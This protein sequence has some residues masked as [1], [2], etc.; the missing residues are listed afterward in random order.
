MRRRVFITLLCGALM[1]SLAA[2]Q[3]WAY[4]SKDEMIDDKLRILETASNADQITM[5]ER[6]QW[7]GLSDERLYGEIASIAPERYQAKEMNKSEV[8]LLSHRARALGYSGDERYVSILQ[9]IQNTGGHRSLRGHAK[10]AIE[11]MERFRRQNELVAASELAEDVAGAR[12]PRR[13]GLVAEGTL[14]VP[15][16]VGRCG[17]TTCSI[18]LQGLH[19]DPVEIAPD[20]ALK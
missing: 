12:W 10:K 19:H 13:D 17:V 3:A 6:L 4:D 16:Q 15:K 18:L 1:A 9:D 20:A 11:D 2:G 5:L 8:N 7:S 14:N